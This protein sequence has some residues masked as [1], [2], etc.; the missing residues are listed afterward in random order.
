MRR[1]LVEVARRKQ[2][3]RRGGDR[4]RV[5]LDESRIELPCPP[6]ELLDLDQ[7]LDRLEQLDGKK[8]ELVKLRYFA[9]LT[10]PQAAAVLG[11]STTTADRYWAYARAWLHQEV[12][13]TGDAKAEN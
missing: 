11:I 8:A 7:A 13:G 3:L 2:A 9:G 5:P 12:I 1:I 4:Q 10:V 6:D